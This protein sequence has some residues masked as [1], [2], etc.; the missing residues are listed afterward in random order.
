MT[1]DELEKNTTAKIKSIEHPDVALLSRVMALGLIPGESVQVINLAPLG[2]PI[3][4]KV[5]DTFISVRK[6]DAKFIE[7]EV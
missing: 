4:I 3:Q 7:V 2:C 6:A 5:G 1:L